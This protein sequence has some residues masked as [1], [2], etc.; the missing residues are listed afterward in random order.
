MSQLMI[1]ITITVILR[2]VLSFVSLPSASLSLPRRFSTLLYAAPRPNLL[3]GV[4][5]GFGGYWPGDPL[6]KR[7]N[8]TIV[9]GQESFSLMVPEDRYIYFYFEEQGVDLPIVNKPRMCRQ[10]CCTICTAKVLTPDSEV[11]MDEPLGVLLLLL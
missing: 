7:H 4:E 10:G 2:H 9:S 6:A 8:V 1:T 11:D 5:P 3:P